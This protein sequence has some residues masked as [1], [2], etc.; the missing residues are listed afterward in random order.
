MSAKEKQKPDENLSKS[1]QDHA[2]DFYPGAN[3]D[4]ADDE[5]VTAQAV[6]NRVK[7]QNNNP[8][9]HDLF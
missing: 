3:I 7:T 8:R 2:A 4:I 5:K 9:S 1:V 6:K